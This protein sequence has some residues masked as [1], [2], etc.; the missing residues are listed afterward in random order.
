MSLVHEGIAWTP[1]ADVCPDTIK[2][3]RGPQIPSSTDAT[4]ADDTAFFGQAQ[5]VQDIVPTLIHM[6]NAI[7]QHRNARGLQ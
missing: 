3:L 4:F 6:T 2:Q 1:P 7:I 5:N